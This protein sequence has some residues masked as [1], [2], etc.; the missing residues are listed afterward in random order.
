MH[1]LDSWRRLQQDGL[2]HQVRLLTLRSHPGRQGQIPGC[3]LSSEEGEQEV[4]SCFGSRLFFSLV[5]LV[6][7]ER[8]RWA[9]SKIPST[10]TLLSKFRGRS[11]DR[12][13]VRSLSEHKLANCR[14][15]LVP[16]LA[17]IELCLWRMLDHGS[18][19]LCMLL[20]PSPRE[21][22]IVPVAHVR[23]PLAEL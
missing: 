15:L 7:D 23:P 17:R 18:N 6:L 16:S 10:V 22:R 2:H 13:L 12:A 9:I 20:V 5:N 21:D 3:D 4:S 19:E 11:S 14:V 1:S 8:P